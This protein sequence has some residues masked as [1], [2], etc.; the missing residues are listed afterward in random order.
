MNGDDKDDD[1]EVGYGKPPKHSQFR[2][3]QSGNPRGAKKGTR[4]LKTDLD[5]ALRHK[6]SI[7]LN[8]KRRTGTTQQITMLTLALKASTGDVR[9]SKALTDLIIA[10]FGPGDRGGAEPTLSARDEALLGRLLGQLTGEG[11]LDDGKLHESAPQDE[12]ERLG[13][14]DTGPGG[15]PREP[16]GEASDG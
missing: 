8:G 14:D 15:E 6:V 11:E 12:A 13:S 2:P 4:A 9:A 16:K 3:G 7:M 1:Y 10:I 5:K